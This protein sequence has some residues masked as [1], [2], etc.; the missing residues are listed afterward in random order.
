MG[1]IVFITFSIGKKASMPI[2]KSKPEQSKPERIPKKT[3]KNPMDLLT[4]RQFIHL[5]L[6]TPILNMD[7]RNKTQTT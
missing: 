6:C 7:F 1:G 3:L 5:F 4:Q 2:P